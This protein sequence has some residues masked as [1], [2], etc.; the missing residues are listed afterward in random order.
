MD[1]S[2]HNVLGLGD[3]RSRNV[4]TL[5]PDLCGVGS[6]ACG[7]AHTLVLSA[8][9][10]TVWSFG[11]GEA[12]KLGHGDTSNAYRPRVI[13]ALQGLYIRKV[14]AG[15]QFSLALTCNGSVITLLIFIKHDILP[16]YLLLT[17]I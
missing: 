14:A 12:G 11:S 13:E 10:K 9:G 17:I 16:R 3:G 7:S 4:P 15:S 2:F 1:L 8:D 5:V 6:V